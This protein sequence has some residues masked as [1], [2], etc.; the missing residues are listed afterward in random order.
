MR[1]SEFRNPVIGV[2]QWMRRIGNEFDSFYRTIATPFAF[3]TAII[4]SI[5]LAYVLVNINPML[6]ILALFAIPIG[7]VLLF[8][9]E[10]GLLVII[11][12]LPLEALNEVG[13]VSITKALSVVVF[14]AA[15]MSF[16]LFDRERLLVK[17]P[18]NLLILLFIIVAIFSVIVAISPERTIGRLMKLFRVAALYFFLVNFIRTEKQLNWAI[19]VFVLGGFASSLYGFFDPLQT[20]QR[21]YGALGQPNLYA[22]S[23]VVRLPI[24]FALIQTEKG[25]LK[26]ILLLFMFLV[27]IY[28][29]ILSGSR[30]GLLALGLSLILFVLVQEKKAVWLSVMTVVFVVG[31][32]IMPESVK[33]RVGITGA[34]PSDDAGNSTDRRESYQIFGLEVWRQNPLFGVGLDGFAEAY[35]QSE[36][37]FLQKGDSLRIAH[38]T[39]MEILVGTGVVGTILFLGMLFYPLASMWNFVKN[40]I[41][42]GSRNLV[43]LSSGVFSGLGGYYLGILFGS[44]QYEKTLWFIM[45]I[46]VIIYAVSK[47]RNVQSADMVEVI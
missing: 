35:A 33:I 31:F 5:G 14:G 28:G 38:N 26:K 9:P 43:V 25:V 13:S 24:I 10:I 19:W 22:L 47:S 45:A 18:Q 16:I 44:R 11:F 32:L 7:I 34:Q 12:I 4:L 40:G 17:S 3:L 6:A 20:G 27:I 23:M 36:Y 46:P 8:R 30:G 39:Y 29:V 37:R 15:I 21:F 41:D 42:I 1:K 2:L